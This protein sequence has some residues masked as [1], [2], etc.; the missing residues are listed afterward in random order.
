MHIRNWD[1]DN[2]Q[3]QAAQ[4]T[5]NPAKVTETVTH[6]GM[7]SKPVCEQRLGNGKGSV[8]VFI[9]FFIMQQQQPF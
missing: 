3:P 5:A 7:L 1:K 9:M 6:S 4:S 8:V 2:G